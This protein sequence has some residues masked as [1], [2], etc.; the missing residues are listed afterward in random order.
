M[1]PLNTPPHME[2]VPSSVTSLTYCIPTAVTELPLSRTGGCFL[3]ILFLFSSQT[4]HTIPFTRVDTSRL[5]SIYQQLRNSVNY[6]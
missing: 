4:G 5:L 2:G 6:N 1:I 3:V